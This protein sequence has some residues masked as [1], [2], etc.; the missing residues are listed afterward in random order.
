M[1]WRTGSQN[2]WVEEQE[3][4]KGD[5]HFIVLK[6][7]L[8][9]NESRAVM[10]RKR[11]MIDCGSFHSIYELADKHE[12]SREGEA[13]MGSNVYMYEYQGNQTEPGKVPEEQFSYVLQTWQ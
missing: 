4:D 5:R 13:T 12:D 11:R 3:V 2:A 8:R 7:R 10:G 9:R 6:A 1:K